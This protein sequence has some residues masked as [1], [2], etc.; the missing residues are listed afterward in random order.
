[1]IAVADMT[2]RD[3][4]LRRDVWSWE[5]IGRGD[6]VRVRGNG[7]FQIG[8]VEDVDREAG[9]VRV[10]MTQQKPDGKWG[11]RYVTLNYIPERYRPDPRD[12][13]GSCGSPLTV[14]RTRGGLRNCD[15]PIQC[16]TCNHIQMVKI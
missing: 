12:C 5:R 14:L 7:C 8:R 4:V 9:T 6:S 13:C 3:L 10:A 16:L 15:Y 11:L 2:Q 1:M